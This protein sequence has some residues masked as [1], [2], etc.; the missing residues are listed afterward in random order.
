MFLIPGTRR[1]GQ[2]PRLPRPDRRHG[3][4]GRDRRHRRRQGGRAHAEPQDD[5]RP[6]PWLARVERLFASVSAAFSRSF[7]RSAVHTKVEG[8]HGPVVRAHDLCV[9]RH[10]RIVVRVAPHCLRH[11]M[12]R[13]RRQRRQRGAEMRRGRQKEH[14][15]PAPR[16][17]STQ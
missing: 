1:P 15:T 9:V 12:L 6:E 14:I 16:P 7:F 11:S 13:Q 8:L 10:E 17:L 3:M 5:R 4:D 2:D